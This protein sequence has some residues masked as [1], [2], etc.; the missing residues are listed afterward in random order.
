MSDSSISAASGGLL[1]AAPKHPEWDGQSLSAAVLN[2]GADAAPAISSPTLTG[3]PLN[4]ITFGQ[5]RCAVYHLAG[6]LAQQLPGTENARVTPG[7]IVPISMENSAAFTIAFHAVSYAGGVAYPHNSAHP[8]SLLDQLQRNYPTRVAPVVVTDAYFQQELLPLILEG[9]GSLGHR[10]QLPAIHPAVDRE[11]WLASAAA[12]HLPEQFPADGWRD[13]VPVAALVAS[14]GTSGTPKLAVLNHYSL[15]HNAHAFARALGIRSEDRAVAPLPLAHIYG[16]N[17]TLNAVLSA[18]GEVAT[19]PF[20]LPQ[21]LEA[22]SPAGDATL[23]FIAPPIARALVSQLP[24][25]NHSAISSRL[26]TFISG[27]AAL[28]STVAEELAR[29][30]GARVAQGYGLTEASPVTHFAT[31]PATPLASVGQALQGTATT[32]IPSNSPRLAADRDAD[33]VNNPSNA[34]TADA[35]AQQPARG[36]LL[37]A[38]PQVMAG[39]LVDLPGT[40][41]FLVDR[42]SIEDGWLHTGDLVEQRGADLFVLDRLRD[43]IKSHGMSL[44][45]QELESRLLRHPAVQLAAVVPGY[46]QGEEY[47]H[48]VIVL[49]QEHLPA[50]D[51]LP[52]SGALKRPTASDVPQANDDPLHALAVEILE[53]ANADLAGFARLRGYTLVDSIP[54]LS[55]GKLQ[56][57]ILRQQLAEHLHN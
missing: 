22:L 42:S 13:R 20:T 3:T 21:M 26:R 37:V 50:A 23:A 2:A 15:A 46:F 10:A 12:T 55:A 38:G 54:M 49:A 51:T 43:V 14:S 34:T 5:L 17:T 19:F 45:P 30:T 11:Q 33:A 56:R 27:A 29:R 41:G 28:P 9:S 16:L 1:P 57:Q 31:D 53:Q 40:G 8:T 18:G 4:R 48:A 6:H 47:P 32:I 52:R 35:E 36:E 39:Y 25:D 24:H 7:L 44:A